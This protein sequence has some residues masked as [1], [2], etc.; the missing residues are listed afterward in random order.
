MQTYANLK[1]LM[2]GEYAKLNR[3]DATTARATGHSASNVVEEMAQVMEELVAELTEKHAKQIETLIKANKEAIDKL[4]AA[5]SANKQ[6]SAT[7]TD[8]TTKAEKKK[9]WEERKKAWDEKRKNAP[10][11]PHCNRKHPNQTA[12]QCWE[13]PANADKRQADWKSVKT[14]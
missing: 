2:C 11:C 9:A 1:V 7:T 4:T 14:T 3:Q 10:T 12:D 5:I 6:P 8:A 13:L